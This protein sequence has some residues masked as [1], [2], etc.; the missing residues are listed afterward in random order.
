MKHLEK[1]RERIQPL[2]D[3]DCTAKPACMNSRFNIPR[4]RTLESGVMSRR[5]EAYLLFQDDVC[6]LKRENIRGGNETRIMAAA[7]RPPTEKNKLRY[8]IE[9]VEILSYL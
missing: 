3:D 7:T 8:I 2:I 5:V 9:G 1:N 4:I 6:W